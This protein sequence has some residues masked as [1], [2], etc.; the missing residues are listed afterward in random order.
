MEFWKLFG[1][2][3]VCFGVYL[4][5]CARAAA[6]PF[7]FGRIV[8][9]AL[10]L[11]V[12]L[13]LAM[14]NLSDDF[15]RFVFDGQ[16]IRFG[17]NPYLYLP[18][19]S[20]AMLAIEKT[21]YWETL[22]LEMNSERYY[23][24]YPPLH[25]LFFW[26]SALAGESLL[27][28]VIVLRS[29]I[30]LFEAFNLFLISRILAQWE[31]PQSKLWLYALNPLV[32]LE[33]TGNLH[34]EGMVLTG[35]LAMVYFMGKRK[36]I[37]AIHSWLFAVG[38]KLLPLI[39]APLV[40]LSIHK[41]DRSKVIVILVLVM[42]M[43]LSPLF[44]GDAYLNFWSSFRLYQSSFEFNASIYYLLR[45]LSGFWLDYNPI[46]KLGPILNGIALI[47]VL[48]VSIRVKVGGIKDLVKSM[49]WVYLIYLL[50]QTTIHP[51]Y[52]IPAFGLGILVKDRIFLIWTWLVF[53]SYHAY[54]REHVEE[55]AIFLVCQYAVL[56]ILILWRFKSKFAFL[57]HLQMKSPL[58]LFLFSGF[59][60]IACNSSP[61]KQAKAIIDA[62]VDFH[63]QIGSWSSVDPLLVDRYVQHFNQEGDLVAVDKFN[64][65]FRLKPFFEAKSYW[66]KDSV[67][68]RVTL[69]GLKVSYWMG[70]N[71][72]LNEGF[73]ANKKSELESFYH[74][75]TFPLSL[76]ANISSAYYQ[77][78]IQLS[79]NREAEIVQA[80]LRNGNVLT[81]F[82]LPE[83]H[84]FIGYKRANRGEHEAV[85][86]VEVQQIKGVIFPAKKEVF[87]ADSLGNHL[88]LKSIITYQLT[89]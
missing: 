67:V 52:L 11:R 56:L 31:L 15:Y 80:E 69:D 47:G 77:N 51:W 66:V 8:L 19:E 33:L 20:F 45:W 4:I 81:L 17:I 12:L 40:L 2:Y 61:E 34:F 86:T 78:K 27:A 62:S 53:F 14:P 28:N 42:L 64:L 44:F 3:S 13:L 9:V 73:L 89:N 58:S 39:H 71:E 25:Q 5:F 7:S 22:L 36:P 82:F 79:D 30:L 37:T 63:D 50:L 32:I 60:L 65:E 21:P 57:N 55:Q 43:L 59:L 24:I 72:V 1:L 76:N 16:L 38:V 26:L 41:K 88:F 54:G 83:N 87:A 75:F 29:F 18:S 35:L 84:Q 68:H 23:S 10:G 74:D 49:V 48:C 70:Q 46:Q 6:W 85:N